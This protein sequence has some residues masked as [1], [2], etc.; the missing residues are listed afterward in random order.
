MDDLKDQL[1]RHEGLLE[2]L[3]IMMIMMN[4]VRMMMTMKV[5]MMKMILIICR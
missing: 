3:T 5:M 4:I 2:N 1:Q